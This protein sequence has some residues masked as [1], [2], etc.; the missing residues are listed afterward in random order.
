MYLKDLQ[1]RG[2]RNYDQAEAVFS[3]NINVFLGENAQGK[4]NMME[5][6]YLLAMARSH[7]TA[8]DKELIG[9]DQEFAKVTGRI[10]KTQGGFPL[11][12][13]LSKKGKKAK[14]NHLEQKKLS[15]YIGHLNVILFAP[16]DLSLVKGS[17]SV[18]RKFLDMEM[19]QMSPIYLHHLV[20]YQKILKQRN[21]YLKQAR[22]KDKVDQTYLDVLTDQ[23]AAEGA[24]VLNERF[25][26]TKRLQE[27]AEPIHRSISQGKEQLRIEYASSIPINSEQDKTQLMNDLLDQFK[28]NQ[29]RELDQ[30]T[31]VSGPHRD[32][33]RFYIND[34]NVQTYGSQGQ[35][36][37]TALSVKLAEIELMFEMTGEYPV[38]L[39]DDVLSELD[40]DRQTHLLKSIQDK[41]QTFLTTTSLD[42]VK[43]ELLND[44]R[45]FNVSSGQIKMESE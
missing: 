25:K 12:I 23:L 45:I 16:E 42:G 8:N 34:K 44:P 37:T 6:I 26:F 11:E 28:K 30:G 24:E 19:G 13:V 21:H 14:L 2:Y 43:K 18:R 10:E 7:R 9:W 32:D 41:V 1:L 38:L 40:D 4:T 3:Q 27:W 35:Q 5:S 22:F 31:T 29:Q 39:L 33:L 15:A 36:R 20:E 17:P